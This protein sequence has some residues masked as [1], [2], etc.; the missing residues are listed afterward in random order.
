MMRRAKIVATIGP[1]SGTPDKLRELILAGVNV[2]RVNMS[3]GEHETHSETIRLARLCAGKRRSAC[4]GQG[5]GQNGCPC[6]PMG[7]GARP[8][9]LFMQGRTG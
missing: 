2:V 9:Q 6:K 8:G 7:Q 4:K 3:H 5:H 1:A